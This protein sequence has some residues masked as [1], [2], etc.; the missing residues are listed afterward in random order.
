MCWFTLAER[1]DCNSVDGE[2]DGELTRSVSYF[3]DK[4][5]AVRHDV[6]VNRGANA[7]LVVVPLFFEG[8]VP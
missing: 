2:R 6:E 5:D 7:V 8:T 1:L 4:A 3:T